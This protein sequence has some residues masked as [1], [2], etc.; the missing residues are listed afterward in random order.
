MFFLLTLLHQGGYLVDR[1]KHRPIVVQ[2]LFMASLSTLASYAWLAAPPAW[3]GTPEPA[4]LLYAIGHGIIPCMWRDCSDYNLTNTFGV[5]LVVI[6][7]QLV[8]LKYVSTALG[9]HKSVSDV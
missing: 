1:Y 8:H 3:T 5:L 6:V 9:V 4:I 7:P 2:L